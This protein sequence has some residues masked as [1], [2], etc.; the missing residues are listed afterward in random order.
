MG[1][2]ERLKYIR[3]SEGLTQ[4]EFGG[5]IGVSE[6][7]ISNYESEKRPL[8]DSL[9]KLVCQTFGYYYEW[10]SNGVD[11]PKISTDNKN[12]TLNSLKEEF[13]LTDFDVKIMEAYL[14]FSPEERY[15]I[16][17]F[18]KIIRDAD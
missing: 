15:A 5:K 8:S 3:K 17:K 2:G 13:A 14:S 18:I 4:A 7:A 12:V 16:R 6:S 9:I 1:I 10:L 11:P